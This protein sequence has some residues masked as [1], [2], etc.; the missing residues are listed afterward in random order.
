MNQLP[1]KAPT[2]DMTDDEQVQQHQ[3]DQFAVQVFDGEHNAIQT[4]RLIIRFVDSYSQ[5]HHEQS[6]NDWLVAELHQYPTIWQDDA[7]LIATA[8]E[9]IISITVANEAK[10]ALYRH[11]DQGK[12]RDSWIAERIES[13]AKQA[14]VVKVGEYAAGIDC[15]L[16]DANHQLSQRVFNQDG[17]VSTNPHLH[18]LLAESDIAN[19]FNIRAT[20][21][22]STIRAEVLNETGWNSHDIV[23]K[24]GAG[25]VIENIQIKS[26]AD[27]KQLIKNL[28][29][30]D[31]YPDGTTI[32]VH[33][34]QVAQVQQEFPH[35]KVT[36]QL[37]VDDV[38][39]DMP[40][41]AELKQL[42][43]NAQL[44]AEIREYDWNEVNRIQVAKRIGTQALAGAA[45]VA[46]MQGAR[47]LGRRVWN[48]IMGQDNP[49]LNEDMREFFTSSIKSSAHVGVQVAVSGAVVVAVKNG[50]LGKLLRSTPAGRIANSVYIG[51]ENAKLLYQ[52]AKGELSGAETLDAMANVSC[53]A[54]AGLMGA[55]FGAIKGAAF[56]TVLGPIGSVLGGLIGG[57]VGGIAGSSIG[58][59]VYAGGKSIVKT[60]AHVLTGIAQGIKH[61][62][63]GIARVFNPAR[64][65]A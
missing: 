12:S 10:T 23:L 64:W 26:Y 42:Q 17:A 54:L 27:T 11:V 37:D 58:E 48:A 15:A 59:L 22:G 6:L 4:G 47:I 43:E 39:V 65:F 25:N 50:L 13:G 35:R 1:I 52:Y 57:V 29:H 45:I 9:I 61:V 28:K 7:D 63:S 55:G 32:V 49:P 18:G 34:D 20:T 53:S 44:R 24:D 3:A 36:S 62:A 21:S 19:Q 46:G 2:L 33:E 14:G 60:A 40:S 30:H 5:R 16:A 8:H 31:G 41:R 56:G 51:M 38:S